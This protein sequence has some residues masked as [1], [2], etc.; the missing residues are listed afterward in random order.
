MTTKWGKDRLFVLATNG[1]LKHPIAA[2]IVG[3]YPHC[4]SSLERVG[5]GAYYDALLALVGLH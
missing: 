2:H 5:K 3:A 4:C 1:L